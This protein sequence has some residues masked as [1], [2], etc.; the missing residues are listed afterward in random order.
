MGHAPAPCA[1]RGR[2]PRSTNSGRRIL[3]TR[4]SSP[5]ESEPPSPTLRDSSSPKPRRPEI[6]RSARPTVRS[7]RPPKHKHED[8]L[9]LC[10]I[11][12]NYAYLHRFILVTSNFSDIQLLIMPLPSKFHSAP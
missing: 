8:F 1:R 2:P 11:F 12:S 7:R 5:V 6:T 3:S 4:A 9:L 10:K